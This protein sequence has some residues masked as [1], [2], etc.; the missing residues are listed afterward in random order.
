MPTQHFPSWPFSSHSSVRERESWGRKFGVENTR[1]WS[2]ISGKDKS[3]A[4]PDSNS[5]HSLGRT[6]GAAG[7]VSLRPIPSLSGS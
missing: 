4:A 2:E 5:H 6:P 1:V 3:W 7:V